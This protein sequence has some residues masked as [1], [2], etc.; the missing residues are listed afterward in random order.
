MDLFDKHSYFFTEGY[1]LDDDITGLSFLVELTD[2]SDYSELVP[3]LKELNMRWF[4][5]ELDYYHPF[6]QYLEEMQ[7]NKNKT[8]KLIFTIDKQ[9]MTWCDEPFKFI[10]SKGN[11]C[12][13]MSLEIFYSVYK[14]EYRRVHGPTKKTNLLVNPKFTLL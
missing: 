9:L 1:I 8:L 2:A 5:H 7:A 11:P 13:V 12:P 14:K 3:L 6:E 10:D 4:V